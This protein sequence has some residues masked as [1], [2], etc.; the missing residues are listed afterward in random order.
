MALKP[1]NIDLVK[2]LGRRRFVRCGILPYYF[3]R[4]RLFIYI[5]LDARFKELTDFAGRADKNEDYII[6]AVRELNEESR[7]AFETPTYQQ[8]RECVCI[9]NET[10]IVI[11]MPTKR[12]PS[13][14]IPVFRSKLN[15]TRAQKNRRVFNEMADIYLLNERLIQ[16][17]LLENVNGHVYERFYKLVSGAVTS[18]E[19]LKA[20][21]LERQE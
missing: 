19:D 6:T 5:G 15:L 16:D 8:I 12:T 20:V 13:Y 3:H 17:E 18:I 14:V 1:G 9:Y 11:F 21:L 10:D 4:K 2:N 7:F